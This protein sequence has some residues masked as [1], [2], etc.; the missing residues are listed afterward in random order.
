[1]R[2][3]WINL[4]WRRSLRGSIF[5]ISMCPAAGFMCA[6]LA[7]GNKN[8]KKYHLNENDAECTEKKGIFKQIGDVSA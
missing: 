4:I 7:A 6:P 8:G 1:M 5:V 3:T 2:E